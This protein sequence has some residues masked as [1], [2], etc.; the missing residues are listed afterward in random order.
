MGADERAFE[1]ELE[2][3]L[4]ALC[5]R[6]LGAREVRVEPLPGELS[7]RRF[8]RLHLH[9]GAV[10]RVVARVE[11]PED[12]RIR[13]A[14]AAPEPPL[15]PLRRVL[16]EAGL[17][18]PARL[19]GDAEAGIELLEDVGD[20]SLRVAAAE[21]DPEERRRLYRE[22]CDLVPRI[23]RV[24]PRPD[25]PAFRRRLD[26]ELV[27]FKAELFARHAAPLALGGRPARPGEREA[28]REGFQAVAEVCVNSPQRLSHRDFQSANLH[29]CPRPS[30]GRLVMIDLQ[31]AFQAPPEYD[32]TCLLRDSYVELPP[33]ERDAHLAR[34]RPA[35]PDAP[36]PETFARRFDLL[37]LTRKG[38]DLARFLQAFGER[39]DRRYLPYV[40]A[41]V[42]A[43]REA[44][45]RVGPDDP[46]LARL[47]ELIAALPEEAPIP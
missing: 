24:A 45:G 40:P 13:P 46:R 10:A 4:V 19:G 16:E 30:G 38:K 44:A 7:A 43:L 20:R 29:V 27:A 2:A 6:E 12:P 18:V 17:P 23:Q 14:G 26:A 31:G 3:T 32:L 25:L 39:G 15:E 41:T 11:A 22:A 33:E 9:G 42:R 5:R 47:A 37:T 34:V 35:L 21:A 36:D 28:V 8:F 1:A